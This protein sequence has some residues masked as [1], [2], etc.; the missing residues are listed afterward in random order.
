MSV[1][2]YVGTYAKYNNGSIAGEW[3]DL[4]M[5]STEDEFNDYITEL[6][7]DESDP[8]FMFQDQEGIPASFFSESGLDR[9]IWDYLN[10]DEN[11]REIVEAFLDCFGDCAGDVFQAAEDAYYGNYGD[12][13]AFAECLLDS[14]GDLSE[15]HQHL[16]YYFDYEAYARDLMINDFRC[17]NNFYFSTNW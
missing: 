5:Y 9:R 10:L 3:V 7:S 11:E 4:D 6:H 14:T 17:S 15:I 2:L 8:E 1:R 16:Q 12:D 13:I